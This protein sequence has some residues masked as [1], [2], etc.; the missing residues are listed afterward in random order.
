MDITKSGEASNDE[1]LQPDLLD[2]SEPFF[3]QL[4][5]F[6]WKMVLDQCNATIQ[7]A[8]C[9]SVQRSQQRWFVRVRQTNMRLFCWL[10]ALDWILQING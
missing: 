1:K 5:C 7:A 4:V 3:K 10:Q 8:V 9:Q 6:V 2:D